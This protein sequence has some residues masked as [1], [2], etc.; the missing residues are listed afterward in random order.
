MKRAAFICLLLLPARAFAND[1]VEFDFHQVRTL[2][3]LP[4]SSPTAPV[5]NP[6]PALAKLGAKKF[7]SLAAKAALIPFGG[8][9]L[10][11][12]QQV[13]S[14]I[15]MSATADNPSPAPPPA[16]TATLRWQN[17]E[18]LNG[19][20]ATASSSELS[21]KTPLFQD[22]LQV[23]WSA[24]DRID[25]PAGSTPP[26]G[27]FS[28]ALRDGS[29]LYGDLA[30]ISGD[31]ITIHSA[32]HGDVALKRS[33]VLSVRRLR[34]DK[35]SL[36]Y[37][38]PTGDVGWQATMIQQDGSVQRGGGFPTATLP[39]VTGPGGALLIRT[40][41]RGGALD[42]AL[43][44]QADVEFRLHSSKRPEFTVALG[45]NP[46]ATLRVETWDDELVIA[47][48]DEF[49]A[50]EKI[51][52]NEREIDLRVCWDKKAQKCSVFSASGE[53]LVDWPVPGTIT[54]A[55]PCLIVQNK[56][57][58]LSLDLLC[59]RTWDGKPPARIDAKQPHVE[60]AD[61]RRLA[62]EITGGVA[63]FISVL[64]PGQT[65]ATSVALADVDALVLSSDAAKISGHDATLAY[66]DG[67][68]ILGSISSITNGRATLATSFAREPL[69]SQLDQVRQLLLTRP[70]TPAGAPEKPL[71]EMDKIVVQGT[72][73]HG[74]FAG[75]GDASPRWTPIGGTQPSR[76]S[77]SLASEIT[78]A[79]PAGAVLPSDPALFYLRSGDVLP[80]RLR[81]FD[82]DGA[83]YESD[84]MAARKLPAGEI[85]AIQFGAPPQINL[86]GFADAGWHIVKGD[87]KSVR[88]TDDK[89]EMDSGTSVS[90]PSLMQSSEIKFNYVSNGFSAVRLRMFCAG[91]DGT[92][93]TNLLLGNT[94]NQFIAGLEAAEGQFGNQTQIKIRQG[95][96]AAVRLEIGDSQVELFVNDISMV[97]VPVDNK[98]VAGAG[99]IIEPASLWGNAIFPVSMA[100]FSATS[101]PGRTWL[102]EVNPDVRTQVLTVPRFQKD[103]PPHHL[104][105]AA[106]GDV[107]RGEVE[108]ATDTHFGFRSGLEQLNVPRDRVKAVIWLK[109]PPKDQ[110]PAAAAATAPANPAPSALDQKIDRRAGFRGVG[111][112]GLIGFLKSINPSLKFKL[113]DQ[114]D[115]RRVQMQ[116]NNQTI[117]EALQTICSMYDL[118]YEIDA[119]NTIVLIGAPPPSGDL[120]HRTYWLKPDALPAGA[121]AVNVLTGKGIT[122]A[123][124]ASAQWEPESGA[125][126]MTNT[127]ENQDKLTALLASDFG[128][129]QG[130]PTHWL[131]LTNG[132]RLGL[133]VDKFDPDFITG[134]HP[135]YGVVKIPMAQVYGIRTTAPDPTATTRSLENW[136]LVNAPD[137]VIPDPSGGNSALL[138]KAASSF[139][140]PLLGGG[141]FDL[142]AQKGRVVVLDFWATWCAP[143]IQSLPGLVEAVGSFPSDKVT[144]IGVNQGESADQ[145]KKFLETRGLK[146]P[147][148]LDADQAVGGKYS[149][150]A[151][152]HT[153]IVGPD[154][155]IAWD[156][157]GYDPD[158]ETEAS[159]AIK[160][161][162]AAPSPAP[163]TDKPATP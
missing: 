59:V 24:I 20:I 85:N 72:T 23:R 58:D 54:T 105:L 151:I 147:V 51:G 118:H 121:D 93:A 100:G 144:L 127:A 42:L 44:D 74:T 153:I 159:D 71:A 140:L 11:A 111:L 110:D 156:Q 19:E 98:K 12:Q 55:T 69:P 39:L 91:S 123:G 16:G 129:S 139:K 60:L 163:P 92:H 63:G 122:F 136:Q 109:P 149:V 75:T 6:P 53:R 89:I 95:D 158:G 104:L 96:P 2:D 45:G 81:S 143:C 161:L 29:F 64:E 157:T 78:R 43:P 21:W 124:G 133:S 32:R 102:P 67:T 40:W 120:V 27:P 31:A 145:V 90:Y 88:K 142:D 131:L 135:V 82:R 37:N 5:G 3:D 117:R 10:V 48:G 137:P 70:A 132:G 134:H 146:F 57:L 14:F 34:R 152:P 26:A 15:H 1:A 107:L 94:G 35:G 114:E 56:G 38:G 138:G 47:S 50:L 49:R 79:F 65:A 99:L 103:D 119:D 68:I 106:N 84:I 126:S 83:E 22:P 17:G 150:D 115:P 80:G 86:H 108:A 154:G 160:K 125:L 66:N 130:S 8:N 112:S 61:G 97:H 77:A 33:E 28:I 148:A 128:G 73:L 116:F 162:L 18:S 101:V 155:K 25:F 41:N 62:G 52:D 36:L 76:P 13:V 141:D 113:P 4:P 9:P 87:E 46:R 7:P 30:S